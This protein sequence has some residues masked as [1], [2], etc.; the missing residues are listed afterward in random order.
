MSTEVI[1]GSMVREAPG[2][3]VGLHVRASGNCHVLGVAMHSETEELFVVYVGVGLDQEE[4]HL[5][6][7][8]V[9]LWTTKPKDVPV[10]AIP[11]DFPAG[12]YRHKKGGLYQILGVAARSDAPELFMVYIAL[13]T[14][15]DGPRI[16]VRP[17]ALWDDEVEWPDGKTRPR[18]VYVGPQIPVTDVRI[19][20]RALS[21]EEVRAEFG[22]KAGG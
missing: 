4:P 12:L 2:I 3:E 1:G 18:F 8:P 17:F 6:V 20:D 9:D 19:Y 22:R 14:D 10:R 15:Y 13:A 5:R 21:S 7:C 11:A 16:R